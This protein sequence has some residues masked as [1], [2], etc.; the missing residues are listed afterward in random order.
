MMYQQFHNQCSPPLLFLPGCSKLVTHTPSGILSVESTPYA[1]L[2]KAVKTGHTPTCAIPSLAST[3]SAIFFRLF[4]VQSHTLMLNPS[5]SKLLQTP[6]VNCR[7][8]IYGPASVSHSITRPYPLCSFP[9][10]SK[11]VT[12]PHLAVHHSLNPGRISSFLNQ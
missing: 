7:Q 4:Q 11:L 12:H 10:C 6:K 8:S 1:I 9:G 2:L 3:P 5:P